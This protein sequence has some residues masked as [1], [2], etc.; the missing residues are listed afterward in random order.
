MEITPFIS[1]LLQLNHSGSSNLLKKFSKLI[2]LTILSY[3][4]ESFKK[5]LKFLFLVHLHHFVE[6]CEARKDED[7]NRSE[8][9]DIVA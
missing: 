5:K 4:Y 6:H 2:F 1:I 8:K 7:P 9:L 3:R